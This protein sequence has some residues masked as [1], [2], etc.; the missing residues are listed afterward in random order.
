MNSRA[1][2]SGFTLVELLVAMTMVVAIV[3]MVYGSYFAVSKA[4]QVY[5]ARMIESRDA[6]QVLRQMARQIRCVYAKSY[7]NK[8]SVESESK[9]NYFNGNSDESCGEILHMVT[10]NAI[11]E[12]SDYADGLFQVTYKFDKNNGLLFINQRRFTGSLESVTTEDDWKLLAQSMELIELRFF[13]GKQW[14]RKWEFQDR[15][16]L[17]RAVRISLIFRGENHRQYSYGT[18][19]YICCQMNQNSKTFSDTLVLVKK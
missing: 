9:P 16:G 11:L 17:P 4:A 14:I 7:S 12:N 1:L 13:D 19:A 2:K 10:T 18:V 3:S 6:Q 8:E 15:A 5:K